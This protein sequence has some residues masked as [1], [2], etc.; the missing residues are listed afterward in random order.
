MDF[1]QMFLDKLGDRKIFVEPSSVAGMMASDSEATREQGVTEMT[2]LLSSLIKFYK[3]TVFPLIRDGIQKISDK[4]KDDIA[5]LLS[6]DVKVNSLFIDGNLVSALEDMVIPRGAYPIGRLNVSIGYDIENTIDSIVESAYCDIS[7][8]RR[9]TAI[10]TINEVIA[11]KI[12]INEIIKGKRGNTTFSDMTVIVN[13]ISLDAAPEGTLGRMSDYRTVLA[14][15]RN[16]LNYYADKI[17]KAITRAVENNELIFD[18]DV[19]GITC[20]APVLDAFYEQGGTI[21]M[22]YGFHLTGNK[23]ITLQAILAK[24]KE[25]TGRY[26]VEYKRLM[27]SKKAL[28]RETYIREY[29]EFAAKYIRENGLSTHMIQEI[30]TRLIG[31]NDLKLSNVKERVE[32]IVVDYFHK[33]SGARRFIDSVN[34][35]KK[36][37]KDINEVI[38][39]AVMDMAIDY[40]VDNLYVQ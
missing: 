19:S 31:M 30:N 26:E 33:E 28:T 37:V 12:D 22:L 17:V 1:V 20:Y 27:L 32:E 38:G 40:V 11:G 25:L 10:D 9:T 39:L 6:Y 21:E 8:E 3:G 5:E 36:D 7:G 24:D 14:A 15:L 29:N 23:A 4:A 34:F 13:Y 18:R 16:N 2:N 35:F